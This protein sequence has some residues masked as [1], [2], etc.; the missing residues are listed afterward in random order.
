MVGFEVVW[1]W[2]AEEVG[3]PYYYYV[4]LLRVLRRHGG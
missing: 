1:G 4:F 2:M 3:V